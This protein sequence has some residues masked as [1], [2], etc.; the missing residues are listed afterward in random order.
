MNWPTMH[1]N[2]N[3]LN[4]QREPKIPASQELEDGDSWSS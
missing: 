2:E 3:Q 4:I 1:A